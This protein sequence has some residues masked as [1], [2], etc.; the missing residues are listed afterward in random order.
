MRATLKI[1]N[2]SFHQT[3]EVGGADDIKYNLKPI[4]AE[5]RA[6][7]DNLKKEISWDILEE[8]IPSMLKDK[9]IDV[10]YPNPAKN[11]KEYKIQVRFKINA[12]G[13]VLQSNREDI[14]KWSDY[15]VIY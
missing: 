14:A 8:Q 10:T 4:V 15:K 12:R 7:R 1:P 11:N 6:K 2:I 3:Y 5:A 9:K 13:K